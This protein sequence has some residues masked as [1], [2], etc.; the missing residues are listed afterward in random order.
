[1]DM[2]YKPPMEAPRECQSLENNYMNCLFQKVMKDRVQSNN[3]KLDA[4]LWFHLECPKAADRFDDP[5]E[6]KRKFREFFAINKSIADQRLAKQ[7]RMQGLKDLYG[8]TRGY[9]EGQVTHPE[10]DKMIPDFEEYLGSIDPAADEIT[11]NYTPRLDD[12]IEHDDVTPLK[13][14]DTLRGSTQLAAELAKQKGN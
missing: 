9:P 7:R 8:Y 12:V 10:A 2:F 3:C 4:I 14:S 5:I 6:F 11:G 13:L 1:M